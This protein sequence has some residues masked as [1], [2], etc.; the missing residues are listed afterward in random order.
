MVSMDGEFPMIYFCSFVKGK[1]FRGKVRG[2]EVDPMKDERSRVVLFESLILKLVA[3]R[4]SERVEKTKVAFFA[5]NWYSLRD[6]MSLPHRIEDRVC[7]TE[8][9]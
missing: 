2:T 1:K 9:C 5:G 3:K 8:I 4:E 6:Q 7:A